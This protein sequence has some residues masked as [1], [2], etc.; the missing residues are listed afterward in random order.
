MLGCGAG[1]QMQAKV[2]SPELAPSSCCTIHPAGML[3]LLLCMVPRQHSMQK[4][5]GDTTERTPARYLVLARCSSV[6]C[7][8]YPSCQSH[9]PIHHCACISQEKRHK[10]TRYR[11]QLKCHLSRISRKF[12]QASCNCGSLHRPG[13][14]ST[15]GG[16]SCNSRLAFTAETPEPASS[17]PAGKLGAATCRHANAL[18][19]CSD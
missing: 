2:I 16:C 19:H 9:I 13:G 7:Q 4:D 14:Q 18:C 6:A 10:R 11:T 8:S 5:A 17:A 15:T 1:L 3:I 12:A